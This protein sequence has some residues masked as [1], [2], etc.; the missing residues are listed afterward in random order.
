MPRTIPCPKHDHGL[1]T[2]PDVAVVIS[3]DG[4]SL[5]QPDLV[6]RL[7][8]VADEP[9]ALRPLELAA[10]YDELVDDASD[11]STGLLHV[12][13][14]TDEKRLMASVGPTGRSVI[15]NCTCGDEFVVDV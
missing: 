14:V 7:I 1:C 11:S 3:G 4:L 2:I 9:I 10:G 13:R 6:E 5:V 15:V 12:A 8:A